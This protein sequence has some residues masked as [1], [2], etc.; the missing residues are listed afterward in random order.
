MAP[1]NEGRYLLGYP[2]LVNFTTNDP[3][4]SDEPAHNCA[5]SVAK[6]LL[7]GD[8]HELNASFRAPSFFVLVVWTKPQQSTELHPF[9]SKSRSMPRLFSSQRQH[10][11]GGRE[12]SPNLGAEWLIMMNGS[13][14]FLIIASTLFSIMQKHIFLVVV[15]V[16]IL[17]LLMFHRYTNN[18]S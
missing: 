8:S 1:T 3:P 13:V 12:P 5:V 14:L 15:G 2:S 17:M 4:V 7:G 11:S 6:G 9:S 18:F 16:P 10:Q